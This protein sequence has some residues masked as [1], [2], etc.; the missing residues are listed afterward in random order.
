[1]P[2]VSTNCP[3]GS[4]FA[5]MGSHFA[6]NTTTNLCSSLSRH[7]PQNLCFL[8]SCHKPHLTKHPQ[9]PTQNTPFPDLNLKVGKI[10]YSMG[11]MDPNW[12]KCLKSRQNCFRSGKKNIH[13]IFAKPF[14]L[15]CRHWSAEWLPSTIL[16]ICVCLLLLI[17]MYKT[18]QGVAMIVAHWPVTASTLPKTLYFKQTSS[19]VLETFMLGEC[20]G[21][22]S[23][24][25]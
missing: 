22:A 19:K 3:V 25:I 13:H 4:H 11:K 9:C 15:V 7:N 17:R 6:Q 10:N 18:V 24:Q 8:H 23:H 16:A 20:C 1:M 12:P 5:Q 2:N 14:L 21:A